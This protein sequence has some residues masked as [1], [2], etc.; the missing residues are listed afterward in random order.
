MFLWVVPLQKNVI[1]FWDLVRKNL[2]EIARSP[3]QRFLVQSDSPRRLDD[4][5]WGTHRVD[6]IEQ[7]RK[8]LPCCLGFNFESGITAAQ[9][10]DLTGDGQ[11]LVQIAAWWLYVCSNLM[12]RSEITGP[13]QSCL[14][15]AS[16]K[17]DSDFEFE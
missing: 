8:Y 3:E 10:K 1:I 12:R 4:E 2:H 6:T 14:V 7:S 17:D 5:N 11:H 9:H 15:S 16:D 13:V